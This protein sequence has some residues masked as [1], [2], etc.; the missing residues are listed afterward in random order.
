MLWAHNQNVNDR[1]SYR[2][3]KIKINKNASLLQLLRRNTTAHH[4]I[5]NMNKNVNIQ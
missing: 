3:I 4:S 2:A 5:I 1:I